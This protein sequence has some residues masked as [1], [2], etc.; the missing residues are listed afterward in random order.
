MA[1]AAPEIQEL[2]DRTQTKP[3]IPVIVTEKAARE[4]KNI[5]FEQRLKTLAD[6]APDLVEPYKNL[7]QN[8]RPPTLADLAAKTGQ[9]EEDLVR[10]LGSAA[11]GKAEHLTD[12]F[13]EP[14]RAFQA[15]NGRAPSS[16]ELASQAGIPEADL[17]TKL[18]NAAAV[19]LRLVYLRLRVVGGG[20]SGFQNKLDLDPFANPN[21]DDTFE[22]H[23]VP[24]V[25]DR[26]S[27]MY[28]NGVTVD[29]HDDINRRGFSILNPSAKGTCGCG[30][31]FSM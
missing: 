22:I 23:D 25:V 15:A 31:S 13:R 9:C 24:I 20:C 1:I 29:F 5:V 11:V 3:E 7:R 19:V 10:K 27:R 4:V 18:G 6:L 26:R 14:Y 8:D 30:S 2:G 21:V 28:L 12:E 16:S 17:L